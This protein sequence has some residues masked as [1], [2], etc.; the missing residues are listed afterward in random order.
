MAARFGQTRA[1]NLYPDKPSAVDASRSAHDLFQ[2]ISH[3][4][5]N[6]KSVSTDLTFPCGTMVPLGSFFGGCPPPPVTSPATRPDFRR[7]TWLPFSGSFPKGATR[8]YPGAQEKSFDLS[9]ASLSASATGVIA[10]TNRSVFAL[11]QSVT[12]LFACPFAGLKDRNLRDGQ[13]YT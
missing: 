2:L 6:T 11:S 13:S 7:A 8:F 1:A 10:F 5:R 12:T 3:P 9:L 4:L